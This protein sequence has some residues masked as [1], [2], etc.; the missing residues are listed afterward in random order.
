ME[1]VWLMRRL[2]L[3]ER[4]TH[5]LLIV[6]MLGSARL[7]LLNTSLVVRHPS[8]PQRGQS[9]VKFAQFTNLVRFGTLVSRAVRVGGT[10]TGKNRRPHDRHQPL[11]QIFDVDLH[12]D[13][14]R[15]LDTSL[16]VGIRLVSVDFRRRYNDTRAGKVG[17]KRRTRD[18]EIIDN[19]GAIPQGREGHVAGRPVQRLGNVQKERAGL[20]SDGQ[21]H[22]VHLDPVLVERIGVAKT[23]EVLAVVVGNVLRLW[24]WRRL[25]FVVDRFDNNWHPFDIYFIFR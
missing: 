9:N 4:A 22:A 5:A 18:V 11:D 12:L 15:R 6:M 13:I 23:D 21:V 7:E 19:S 25:D 3:V 16:H 20:A 24:W 2:S 1:I 10:R 8:L 17:I 14:D